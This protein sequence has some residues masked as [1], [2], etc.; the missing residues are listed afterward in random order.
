MVSDERLNWANRRRDLKA[1]AQH[2]IK[3]HLSEDTIKLGGQE[4]IRTLFWQLGLI[5]FDDSMEINLLQNEKNNG[6]LQTTVNLLDSTHG[7]LDTRI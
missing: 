4:G 5:S 1:L 7:R 2:R 6:Q 3:S